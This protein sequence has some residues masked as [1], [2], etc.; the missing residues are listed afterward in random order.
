MF[1]FLEL[2]QTLEETV[3]FCLYRPGRVCD[4]VPARSTGSTKASCIP[5]AIRL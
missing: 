2:K 5:E 1:I 3:G 4:L